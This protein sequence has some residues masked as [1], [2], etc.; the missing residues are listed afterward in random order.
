MRQR[1]NMSSS[2]S[3]FLYGVRTPR[4]F[5]GCL[6]VVLSV[7]P[8]FAQGRVAATRPG[9]TAVADTQG[10]IVT[11]GDQ[12]P[13]DFE[14]VLANGRKTTLRALRGKVVVLEFTASW[15]SVCR[16]EM[17]HL[18]R[19]VWQAYKDKG[20]VLIGVDRDEPLEIVQKFA[21]EM[22][23]TYPLALDPGAGI[24]NRF[25]E[26]NAG[27]TRNVVIDPHGKI[28]LLTRLYDPAEF[29]T[30]VDEIGRQVAKLTR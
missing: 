2:V 7:T 26:Q 1:K 11:I 14:L 6:A 20:L 4:L 29:A 19:E 27:V 22:H 8:A 25:A 5:F 13:S 30:M 9:A 23:I 21:R 12:A 28:V 15:C 24:I 18:E 16:E 3:S 10:Y 17:P